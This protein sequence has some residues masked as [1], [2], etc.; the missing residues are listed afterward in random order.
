[1]DIILKLDG[2]RRSIDALN[3]IILKHLPSGQPVTV[4]M[5]ADVYETRGPYEIKRTNGSRRMGVQ[6]N[7]DGRASTDVMAE[8]RSIVEA[9]TDEL[10]G[11]RFEISGRLKEG[12]DANKKVLML[13]MISVLL[14]GLSLYFSYRSLLITLQI[15][16][17]IP[18]A[19]IGAIL[20]L[21]IT[22]T[23]MSIA[24]MVGLIALTGIASRNGILM[25]SHMNHI[26][27]SEGRAFSMETVM[28]GA[29]ER[30]IPVLMTASTAA[31]AL[32]PILIT[33]SEAPGKEILFPVAVVI[34]GGLISSTAIDL[35]LTPVLY[36]HI[37]KRFR[38][39]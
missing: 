33:G 30:L 26:I 22:N 31:L 20:G 17:N 32:L 24:T 8:V 11:M 18:I 21:W 16:I 29:L 5:I 34:T 13:A 6:F 23:P 15:L 14:I 2:D 27:E 36:Y 1:F 19:F 28:H 9:K 35:G 10:N 12:E 3:S 39:L 38:K 37:Q 7:I 25:I 4:D